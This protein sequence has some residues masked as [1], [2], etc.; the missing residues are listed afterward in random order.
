MISR[1]AVAESGA[2][3]RMLQRFC[4]VEE[5]PPGKACKVTVNFL[6]YPLDMRELHTQNDDTPE[7]ERS[8]QSDIFECSDPDHI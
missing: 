1:E 4:R 5:T 7:P 6:Y 3:I 8:A 2:E